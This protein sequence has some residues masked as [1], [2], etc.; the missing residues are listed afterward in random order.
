ML[1]KMAEN[2]VTDTKADVDGND[3]DDEQNNVDADDND[4]DDAQ[5]N[6]DADDSANSTISQS[7]HA[8]QSRSLLH[9]EQLIHLFPLSLQCGGSKNLS[10]MWRIKK[11]LKKSL[12]NVVGQKISL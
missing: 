4:Y 8:E 6:V 9:K 2:S 3:N 7:L 11:S 10:P 1:K 5:N 12:F